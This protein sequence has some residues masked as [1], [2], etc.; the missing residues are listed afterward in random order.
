M[1]AGQQTLTILAIQAVP[2]RLVQSVQ[3]AAQA[4][5]VFN[6]TAPPAV[7]VLVLAAIK[8]SQLLAAQE[9]RTRVMREAITFRKPLV[10]LVAVA[11]QVE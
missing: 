9:Q 11:A 1:L 7:R 6:K 5:V 2:H 3:Q 8:P 4:V 10:H